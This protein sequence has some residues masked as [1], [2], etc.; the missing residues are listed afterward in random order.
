M[1]SL[2][3]S[4]MITG[5]V[6]NQTF[7]IRSNR[8]P[9]TSQKIATKEKKRLQRSGIDMQRKV[10]DIQDIY[11]AL[12]EKKSQGTTHQQGSIEDFGLSLCSSADQ[13]DCQE[14]PPQP[15]YM[16]KLP[17]TYSSVQLKE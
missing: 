9:Q 16:V 8:I 13:I 2:A 1:Q 10:V 14:E 4:Q 15:D 17:R 11:K 12:R 7:Q 3:A 5:L 6:M